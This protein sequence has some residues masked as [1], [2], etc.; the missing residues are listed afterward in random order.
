MTQEIVAEVLERAAKLIEDNGW[1]KQG[2]FESP[3]FLEGF[4]SE[5]S[6]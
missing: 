4:K 3:R 2:D 5:S 6:D 1:W